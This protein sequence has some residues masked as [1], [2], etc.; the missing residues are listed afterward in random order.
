VFKHGGMVVRAARVNRQMVGQ[1]WAF[2][3]WVHGFLFKSVFQINESNLILPGFTRSYFVHAL[4]A[5]KALAVCS[6]V[7]ATK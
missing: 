2:G 3:S 5:S 4:H 7:S 6:C 1:S